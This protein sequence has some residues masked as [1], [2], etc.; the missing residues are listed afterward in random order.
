MDNVFSKDLEL[1]RQWKNSRTEESLSKL[2][3]QLDPIIK[4]VIHRWGGVLS[5]IVID[6]EAKKM[7]V[8]ALA[9]YDPNQGVKLSTYLTNKLLPISRTIY[10]YQNPVR[11]PE[12]KSLGIQT[13]VRAKTELEDQ[14]GREPSSDEL[15]DYLSWS[16]NRVESFGKIIGQKNLSEDNTNTSAFSHD[17]YSDMNTEVVYFSLSPIQ[18]KIFEYK[19]GYRG[20]KPLSSNEAIRKKLKLETYQYNKE[21]KDIVEIIKKLKRNEN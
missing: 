14:Y 9:D 3:K 13:Y 15:A 11:L 8:D 19:I 2:M 10:T 4:S 20:I 1:W 5:P 21:L 17:R 6:L 7:V 18:K 12:H 16:V